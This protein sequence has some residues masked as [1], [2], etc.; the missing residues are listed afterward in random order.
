MG[1]Q[2]R[3][4]QNFLDSLLSGSLYERGALDADHAERVQHHD[5]PASFRKRLSREEPE[6]TETLS[7]GMADNPFR[8]T[9]NFIETIVLATLSGRWLAHR[10]QSRTVVR[11]GRGRTSKLLAATILNKSRA[12]SEDAVQPCDRIPRVR[13]VVYRYAGPLH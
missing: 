11:F 10:Q 1:S 4:N 7:Q 5:P 12:V 9:S 2:R 6:R 8:P 13:T 3:E